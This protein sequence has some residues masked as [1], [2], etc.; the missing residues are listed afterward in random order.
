MSRLRGKI[1]VW[2]DG[3]TQLQFDIKNVYSYIETLST[4]SIN[5]KLI[6]P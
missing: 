2:Q 6:K 5:P 4:C 3:L 1:A